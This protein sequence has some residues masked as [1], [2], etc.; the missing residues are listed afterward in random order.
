M[1]AHQQGGWKLPFFT[2]WSGQA[3]S[4]FGSGLVQF[5]LVWWLTAETGSATIL[6]LATLTALLPQVILGPVAG[7]LVDRWNRRAVMLI[8]DGA[9]ALVTLW[10]AFLYSIGATEVW[11]VC[12]IILVRSAASAFHWPAM[13]AS[14]SLM[15]PEQHLSRV[16][17]LNQTLEGVVTIVSPPVGA[18]LF[19]VL[20]LQHVLFIDIGT[21]LLAIIPLLFIPI[22]QPERGGAGEKA[23]DGVAS[24]VWGEMREGFQYIRAWPGLMVVIGI[25]LIV[26]FLMEPA[27][28]LLPLLVT[29]HFGGEATE[30]GWLESAWGVGMLAG[31]LALSVWGGFKRRIVTSLVGM[32]GLGG[33]ILLLG[34]S[35]A[36][37][38]GLG[39]AG[40]LLAG[41]MMPTATGPLLAIIQASV[42]PGMQG[43]VLG[44]LGATTW[45]MSPL[46]LVII[47]PLADLIGVRVPYVVGGA[48]LALIGVG[49]FFIPALMHIEE[50][51]HGVAAEGAVAVQP[52]N[53]N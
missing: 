1:S 23:D 53:L 6:A 52:E 29:D 45:A 42:A 15:V 24:S 8:M 48:V 40:L 11:H 3:F 31:G 28:S 32:V 33:G 43:R 2:I 51:R 41:F 30:L 44:I 18:F 22:P 7:A 14:T 49:G 27:F 12:A 5:A 25:G 39:L 10:L 36:A 20:P 26:N 38:L 47:G 13:Q 50:N 35:P 16:A 17:G 9:T 34:L 4:L 37:A 21:A 46:G 19:E